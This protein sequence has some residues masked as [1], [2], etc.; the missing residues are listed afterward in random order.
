MTAKERSELLTDIHLCLVGDKLKNQQ[1]L[2]DKVNYIERQI[3]EIVNR[4]HTIEQAQK[5]KKNFFM[6]FAKWLGAVFVTSKG[7]AG[8]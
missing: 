4:L 6:T 7:A 8:V 5:N 3:P 1:G 2:V